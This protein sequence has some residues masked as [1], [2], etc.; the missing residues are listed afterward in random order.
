MLGLEVQQAS[1]RSQPASTSGRSMHSTAAECGHNCPHAQGMQLG[2]LR[3][4]KALFARGPWLRSGHRASSAVSASSR[5][6]RAVTASVIPCHSARRRDVAARARSTAGQ[7]GVAAVEEVVEATHF[8][9]LSS[10]ALPSA[11]RRQRD[12]Y[13]SLENLES[14][15]SELAEATLDLQRLEQESSAVSGPVDRRSSCTGTVLGLETSESR[16]GLPAMAAEMAEC[17]IIA[18]ISPCRQSSS[19]AALFIR[20]SHHI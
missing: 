20:R 9:V 12:S 8:E 5:A 3:S 15:T 14:L 7:V 17:H 4:R 18:S 6:D 16:R 10:F 11:L 2:L 19:I 1:Q 13:L